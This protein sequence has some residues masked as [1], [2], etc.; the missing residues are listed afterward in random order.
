M[1]FVEGLGPV[2][3]REIHAVLVVER[4]VLGSGPVPSRSDLCCPDG[5]VMGAPIP[6]I[7]AVLMGVVVNVGL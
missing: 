3:S 4:W 1:R 7:H 5:E 6:A 2:P